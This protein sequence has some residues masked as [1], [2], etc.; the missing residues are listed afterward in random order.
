MADSFR[1]LTE[2]PTL[3][4]D[5]VSE[6][7]VGSRLRVD[8]INPAEIFPCVVNRSGEVVGEETEDVAEWDEEIAVYPLP[9]SSNRLFAPRGSSCRQ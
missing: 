6:G 2:I 4:V 5:H 3:S 1:S 9:G 7:E 8:M